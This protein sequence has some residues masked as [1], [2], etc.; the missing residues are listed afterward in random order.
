MPSKYVKK[1]YSYLKIKH[2]TADSES[3]VI[4]NTKN[5]DKIL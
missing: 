5:E 2:W 4:E 1:L 3:A